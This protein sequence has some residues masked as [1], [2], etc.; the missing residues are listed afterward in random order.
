MQPQFIYLASQ[1]RAARS[2]SDQLGVELPDVAARPAARTIETLEEPRSKELP[3]DYVRRV[4]KL[5]LDAARRR[6]QPR[7]AGSP[8]RRS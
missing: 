4:A 6:L 2:C 1:A 5:K 3:A 7:D 8:R